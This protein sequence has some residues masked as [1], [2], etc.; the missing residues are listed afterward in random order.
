M[1]TAIKA[2]KDSVLQVSFKELRETLFAT[3]PMRLDG[4]GTEDTVGRLD[5]KA[6]AAWYERFLSPSNMVI[7]LFGDIDKAKVKVDFV[8]RFGSLKAKEV[9]IK[10]AQE[11]FPET[12]RLKEL[13]MDKE[14]AAVLYGFRA[15]DIHSEE[16]YALEVSVNILSSSLGGRMFKRVRDELGKAYA[17]SGSFSPGVDAGMAVFFT[18]TTNEN[19][20]KVRSLMEEEFKKLADEPVADKELTDAKVYLKSDLARDLQTLSS[21]VMTSALDELLGLGFNNYKSYNEHI[22]AVTKED[23]QAAARKYFDMAHAA[24]VVTRSTAKS[25]ESSKN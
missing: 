3:H 24:V 6:L 14:Q 9:S 2:R 1:L 10:G 16:K 19:V 18:L 11:A 23:V 21:Q 7:A 5:R 22:D 8:K 15:P 17:L 25:K 12:L 13:S 4:L 20:A